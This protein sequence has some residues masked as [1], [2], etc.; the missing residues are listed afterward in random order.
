MS[1]ST[2][3]L[4]AG[5]PERLE[6]IPHKNFTYLTPDGEVVVY[7]TS[8]APERKALAEAI[9][10][11][12]NAHAELATRAGGKAEELAASLRQCLAIVRLQNGNLHDDINQL[13][14]RAQKALLPPAP[15]EQKEL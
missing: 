3:P 4:P 5:L 12:Y 10:E 8:T 9:V 11:R 2:E 1:A 7:C 15:R 14:E 13:M 6:L